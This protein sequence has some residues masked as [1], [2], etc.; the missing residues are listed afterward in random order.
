VP[1][2]WQRPEEYVKTLKAMNGRRQLVQ[3]SS[4]Q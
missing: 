3:L 4:A 2:R 1:F